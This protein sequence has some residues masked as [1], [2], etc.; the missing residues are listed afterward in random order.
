MISS[1]N[2]TSG[3]IYGGTEVT[4]AG[5]GFTADTVV[6]FDTATCVISNVSVNSLTCVTGAHASQTTSIQIRL[7][8]LFGV[9]IKINNI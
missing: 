1:M 4:F 8:L 9:N 7:E 2:P 3:S 6:M 5:N